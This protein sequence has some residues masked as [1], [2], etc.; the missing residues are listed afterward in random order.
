MKVAE[1]TSPLSPVERLEQH[2]FT[3]TE[4]YRKH[5]AY[6]KNEY[7]V[8]ALEMEI[9]QLVLLDGPKKMKEIGGHFRVKLSTLTSIIDKM[10]RGRLV[11]RV[12]SR[13]DRRV[14]FLE[15]TRKGKGLYEGYGQHI[16]E[17]ANKMQASLSHEQFQALLVGIDQISRLME[18]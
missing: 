2:M 14:V 17:M 13:S 16:Q 15:A 11:K 1:V 6:I 8:S 9:L 12:N 4:L 5:Q 7:Q 18:A 10:E 3:L